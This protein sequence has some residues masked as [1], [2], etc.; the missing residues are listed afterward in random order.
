MSDMDACHYHTGEKAERPWGAWAVLRAYPGAI[1]KEIRVN[2]GCRLSLQSHRLRDENWIVMQGTA[3]VEIEG[4]MRTLPE[5][6]VVSVPRGSR[7]RL[8]NSSREPL[9]VIEIQSGELLSEDDIERHEDDY[10]RA[11]EEAPHD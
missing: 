8:G 2:P 6:A 4:D 9:I 10:H 7:H 1:L 5:G 3:T 11:S